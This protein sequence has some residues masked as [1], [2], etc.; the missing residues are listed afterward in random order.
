MQ[1]KARAL[2]ELVTTIE[3]D[4]EQGTSVFKLEDLYTAYE[5]RIRQFHIDVALNRTDT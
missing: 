5:K 3:T 1:A 4:I 2:A